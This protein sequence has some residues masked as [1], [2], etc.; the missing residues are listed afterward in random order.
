VRLGALRASQALRALQAL[1][2]LQALRALG[3][4]HGLAGAREQRQRLGWKRVRL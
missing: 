4:R 1:Q 2:A 3:P